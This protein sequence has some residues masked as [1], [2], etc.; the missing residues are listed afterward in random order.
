MT[1]GVPCAMS[2]AATD[3]GIGRAVGKPVADAH[4]LG[5]D[6]VVVDDQPDPVDAAEA[7][8]SAGDLAFPSALTYG[9]PLVES[10][11]SLNLRLP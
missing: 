6:G 11:A 3:S 2:A 5:S 4:G 9:T 10:M 8:A 1:D 7:G